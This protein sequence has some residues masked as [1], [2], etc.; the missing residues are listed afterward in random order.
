[1][2]KKKNLI[3]VALAIVIV[4]IVSFNVLAEGNNE[5]NK[6]PLD[7]VL[8]ASENIRIEGSDVV[9]KGDVWANDN[10][11][12][13]G[14]T[15]KIKGNTWSSNDI[16]K[17]NDYI[18]NLWFNSYT[19]LDIE[20]KAN[21]ISEKKKMIDLMPDIENVAKNNAVTYNGNKVI[22][23]EDLNKNSIIVTNGMVSGSLT[24]LNNYIVADDKINISLSN[25]KGI[26][27]DKEKQDLINKKPIAIASKKITNTPTNLSSYDSSIYIKSDD[28]IAIVGS[29]YAPNGNIKIEARSIYIVG[30]IIAKNIYLRTSYLYGNDENKIIFDEDL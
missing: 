12:F 16:K 22:S 19:K 29:I 11:T 30:N 23:N 14:T 2:K 18:N 7:Y 4:S 8:F 5:A 20:G 13:Y 9:L 28:G 10:L 17:N 24:E 6:T 21:I 1:M 3:I 25:A 26:L 15:F 27:G